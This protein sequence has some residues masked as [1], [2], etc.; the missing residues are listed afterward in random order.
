[1]HVN[2]MFIAVEY[3]QSVIVAIG[4]NDPYSF[5]NCFSHFSILP[6][7]EFSKRLFSRLWL[8]TCFYC[9]LLLFGRALFFNTSFLYLFCCCR[10]LISFR[11]KFTWL[12]VKQY[13]QYKT[14]NP[15]N[16]RGNIILEMTSIRF[17][18]DCTR[19]DKEVQTVWT[20]PTFPLPLGS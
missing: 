15:A 5:S 4:F 13:D 9:I 18:S 6:A 3:Y 12:L 1:M 19:V 20:A 8:I 7:F 10:Y 14:L 11:F 17:A 16:E 2:F